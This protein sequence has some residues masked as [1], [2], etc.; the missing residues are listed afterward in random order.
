MCR[1]READ[2]SLTCV[3]LVCSPDIGGVMAQVVLMFLFSATDNKAA[4][5]GKVDSVLQKK[6]NKYS[7]P[8]RIDLA[9]STISGKCLM[10]LFGSWFVLCALPLFV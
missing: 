10:A 2:K 8:V 3:L 6:L 9:S 7:G 4:F 1:K 5:L